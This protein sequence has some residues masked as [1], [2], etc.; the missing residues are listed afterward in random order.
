[1][2][3]DAGVY[4]SCGQR[5]DRETLIADEDGNLSCTICLKSIDIIELLQE[6]IQSCKIAG[7]EIEKIA[8][9][10]ER[11]LLEKIERLEER[12]NKVNSRI[13]DAIYNKAKN[14]EKPEEEDDE[15]DKDWEEE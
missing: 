15:D 9:C 12:I 13:D 3:S 14:E 8:E 4:C 1:M 5:L 2:E 11:T 6:I 10:S 7:T